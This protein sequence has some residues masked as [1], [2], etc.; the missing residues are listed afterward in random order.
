[1][2][3]KNY[4]EKGLNYNDYLEKVNDQLE[5]LETTDKESF[6][7][8]HYSLNLQRMKRLNKTVNLSDEQKNA[9]KNI[10][11][12]FELLTISEGWCGDAAQSLPVMNVIMN[13]LCVEQ[14]IVCRD[15]DLG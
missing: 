3:L 4:F 9:L 12:D 1:M 6:V 14:R 11:T 7:I 2:N 8:P 13:E 15:G 10:S 5:T